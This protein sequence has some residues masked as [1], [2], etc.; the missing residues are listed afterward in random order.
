MPTTP[1]PPGANRPPLTIGAL[2][3]RTGVAV[4]AIRYYEH[5]GLLPAAARRD[6]G[7]RVFP[8][9]TPETLLLIRR[10]RELGFSVE[11][12][13][14]LLHL[15]TSRAQACTETHRLALVHL[16]SVRAKM[17]ELHALEHNLERYIHTCSTR[18]LGGPAADCSLLDD[19]RA[20]HPRN[21]PPPCCTAPAP[22]TAP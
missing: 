10:C 19:F 3:R 4:S 20:D 12:V 15:S 17:A 21:T 8:A 7:H 2:A 11:E 18:C 5:I 9:S 1:R 13:K 14:T 22:I 16:Q 6:S